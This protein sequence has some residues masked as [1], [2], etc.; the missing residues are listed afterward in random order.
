MCSIR[1][2]Q[3]EKKEQFILKKQKEITKSDKRG[4]IL[5]KNGQNLSD[6]ETT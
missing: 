3:W 2:L 6:L 5:K 4:G 1:D